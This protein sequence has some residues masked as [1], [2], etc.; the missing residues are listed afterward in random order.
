M[1]LKKS[2]YSVFLFLLSLAVYGQGTD[3]TEKTEKSF[4]KRWRVA[5]VSIAGTHL[6]VKPIIDEHPI[7]SNIA[8]TQ[9]AV[10]KAKADN[11]AL[12]SYP[13]LL[14]RHEN[15]N[16]SISLRAT[17]KPK[18]ID[19]KKLISYTEFSAG[20]N[21]RQQY[22]NTRKIGHKDFNDTAY[23]S[24]RVY[25]SIVA[26]SAEF[27][28]LFTLQT[29]SLSGTLALYSGLGFYGGVPLNKSVFTQVSYRRTLSTDSSLNGVVDEQPFEGGYYLPKT[30]FGFYIPIGIKLNMSTRSNIF[31]EY[32]FNRHTLIFSNNYNKSGWYGGVSFGYRYKFAA[33]PKKDKIPLGTPAKTPEPFY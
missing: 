24:Y 3:S 23:T 1:K 22:I 6:N 16:T 2:L 11:E 27:D 12:N 13:F 33:K 14:E 4:F 19:G 5:G 26:H 8:K 18:K 9:S 31:L 32:I 29:P 25:G 10:N 30:A 21:L 7:F 15:T 20:V 28:M 17:F